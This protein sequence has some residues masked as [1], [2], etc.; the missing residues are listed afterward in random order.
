MVDLPF[1][2]QA[3]WLLVCEDSNV[4]EIAIKVSEDLKE[5]G[6]AEHDRVGLSKTHTI[7]LIVWYN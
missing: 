4:E 7:S 1:D 2:D 3:R 6:T 5:T